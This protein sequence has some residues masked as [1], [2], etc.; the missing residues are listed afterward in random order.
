MIADPDTEVRIGVLKALCARPYHGAIGALEEI[1]EGQDLEERDL[2]EKRALFE[3]YATVAGQ[4]GVP[5]LTTFLQGK[6]GFGRRAS[7]SDIR[8]CAAVAL[9]QIGTPPARKAL[10]KALRDR[11]PVVRS[12]A[13]R[14]L[15]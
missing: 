6:G 8:A 9:G 2:G 11:D 4:G 14:A 10:E 15:T 5:L 13:K 3:T 7:T 1:L 12:A